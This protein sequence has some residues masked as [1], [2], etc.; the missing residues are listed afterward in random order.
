MKSNLWTGLL[1]SV[2]LL[3]SLLFAQESEF[4]E[5]RSN[6]VVEFAESE[7][8]T[9]ESTEVVVKDNDV[10]KSDI[11]DSF[12]IRSL[13]LGARL[14]GMFA[15]PL[16]MSMTDEVQKNHEEADATWLGAKAGVGA[17][18]CVYFYQKMAL[19]T[20]LDYQLLYYKTTDQ[21]PRNRVIT[22]TGTEYHVDGWSGVKEPRRVS[23]TSS[24]DRSI[25]YHQVSVPVSFRYHFLDDLWGQLGVGLGWNLKGKG[26]YESSIT[27]ATIEVQG[28]YQPNSQISIPQYG[29]IYRSQPPI[30]EPVKKELIPNL[31]LSVG[32]SW[33][34]GKW[35]LDAALS[36]SYALKKIDFDYGLSAN[37]FTIG[38]DFY[39]W[40]SLTKEKK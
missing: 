26:V 37:T 8:K 2:S 24:Q 29:T 3:P 12:K 23:K 40:Y 30:E 15:L 21:V 35:N 10:K 38:L 1:L 19:V 34:L 11:D 33:T 28:Y 17:A 32:K 7:Q 14:G 31:L 4:V 20:G 16:G 22:V 6:T 18:L 36:F 27:K 39:A 25:T 5:D 13:L 9:S